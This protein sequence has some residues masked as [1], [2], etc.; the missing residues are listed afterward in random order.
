[1]YSPSVTGYFYN[2]IGDI[3]EDEAML[4]DYIEFIP[5]G[6]FKEKEIADKLITIEL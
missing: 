3:A 2:C 4:Y 6:E 5:L 1:M